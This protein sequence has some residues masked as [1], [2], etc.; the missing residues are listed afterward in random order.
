MALFINERPLGATCT[1]APWLT[2]CN[3]RRVHYDVF[4]MTFA[5]EEAKVQDQGY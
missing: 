1:S 2:A 5:F 3:Q 4:I